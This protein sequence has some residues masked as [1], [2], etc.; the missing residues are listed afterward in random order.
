MVASN[1]SNCFAVIN[2]YIYCSFSESSGHLYRILPDGT[3]K[4]LV[5]DKEC[6]ELIDYDEKLY[7]AGTDGGLYSLNYE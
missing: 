3:G 4:E 2:G 1:I 7:C 6:K 5:L